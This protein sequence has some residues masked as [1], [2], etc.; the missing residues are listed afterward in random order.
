MGIWVCQPLATIEGFFHTGG[1]SA[2]WPKSGYVL[3]PRLGPIIVTMSI[4]ANQTFSITQLAH[5]Q[6]TMYNAPMYKA[7][8]FLV[9]NWIFIVH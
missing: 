7:V 8:K 5:V 6:Y 4:Q 1:K 3:W 2:S 9:L